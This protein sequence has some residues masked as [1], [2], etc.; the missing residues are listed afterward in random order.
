MRVELITTSFLAQ[1]IECH[2]LLCAI[3]FLVAFL[4]ILSPFFH[5]LANSQRAGRSSHQSRGC[6]HT[7]ATM[8]Y[9]RSIFGID[10]LD[11]FVVKVAD[12]IWQYGQGK[13]NLEV[14]L[15]VRQVEGR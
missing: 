14:R 5:A 8:N 13:Q 9:E 10:P 1:N 3:R 2:F 6:A 15:G 7:P 4:H 12:W 11:E